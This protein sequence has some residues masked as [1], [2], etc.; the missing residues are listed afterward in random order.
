MRS[1]HVLAMILAGGKGSR[2]DVLT[3]ERPK[4]VLPFAGTHRLIDFPLSNLRHS[5]IDDVLM[6]VQYHAT[7][8]EQAVGGGRPWDLDR[9]RGG[10]LVVGPEEG[11]GS[12]RSGFSTGNADLLR[13]YRHV[14]REMNPKV[15]LVLS[16]D[17]VYSADYTELI[18]THLKSDADVTVLSYDLSKTEAVNHAVLEI[19][20][21]PTVPGARITGMEYKPTK[22]KSSIVATEVF[23]YKPDVLAQVLEE[24]HNDDDESEAGDTGLGDFGD[25]LLPYLI[26]H[27]TVVSHPHTGYWGD[28]GRPESFLRAHRELITGEVDV[29][30][31]PDWPLLGATTNRPAARIHSSADFVDSLVSPG[32]DIKGRVV[33]SV[34]GPGVIVEEGAEV[35]DSVL[36]ED[37]TVRSGAFVG[38]AIVDHRVEVGKGARIGVETGKRLP[39]EEDISLVGRDTVLDT[40]TVIDGGARLEPGTTA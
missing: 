21:D 35:V 24:L 30:D 20:G 5:R 37:V 8:L 4:P 18:A 10:L 6:C 2:M 22:A 12:E 14:V 9:T 33:R 3:R 1:P 40:R 36:A 31:D 13:R 11:R 34:L 15:L 28:A 19:A 25:K 29:F 39:V 38:T 17:H 27:G 7:M 26:E 16:A 32:C 23:A